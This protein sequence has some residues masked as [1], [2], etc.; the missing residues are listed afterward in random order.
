MIN[1]KK[2][3]HIFWHGVLILLLAQII[4]KG[5]GVIFRLYLTNK[6]GYGDAGNAIYSGGFQIYALLLTV[7]SIGIPN[8]V[9]KLLSEKISIGDE[10]NAIRIFRISILFFSLIGFICSI[11]LYW[12]AKWIANEV[13]QIPESKLT[14]QVLAPSIFFVSIV[15][16]YRGYFSAKHMMKS[17]AIS[18]VLEQLFK[19]FLAFF[20]VERIS[21][22]VSVNHKTELM[23]AGAALATSLATICG[24]IYLFLYAKRHKSL[25]MVENIYQTE[26]TKKILKKIILMSF[27]IT[28]SALLG[29]LNKTIDSITVVRGL[30]NFMDQK[31]AQLQY[32]ILSGKID[33]LITLPMSFNMALIANLIPSISSEKAKNNLV[34]M[35]KRIQS[36]LQVTSFIALP[37]S[38]FLI[39]LADP[40]LKLLFPNASNGTLILQVSSISIIF[41]MMNQTINGILQGVGK[42]Y[43]P[44][45]ITACGILIKTIIN[46][47][48]VKVNPTN[49]AL[50][51][52]VGASCGTIA[53]YLVIWILNWIYL[54]KILPFTVSLKDILIRPFQTTVFTL[55]IVIP[56]KYLLTD[57]WNEKILTCI[58]LGCTIVFYFLIAYIM[59]RILNYLKV[60]KSRKLL[61]NICFREKLQT[62]YFSILF[63]KY[64]EKIRLFK[65]K[66]KK[67]EGFCKSLANNDTSRMKNSLLILLVE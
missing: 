8:V 2:K 7:S 10:K 52:L 43:I 56:F 16:A 24:W 1:L 40:I 61:K 65:N 35:K 42:I 30:Q 57:L 45:G 50:G 48:L 19:T 28:V 46:L 14:L 38:V 53:C 60:R 5:F 26:A 32:G 11:F 29:G 66:N 23:A 55:L 67:K 39:F 18:Q 3:I 64:P 63:C 44:V 54:K 51:G 47:I 49:F 4:V 20:F 12:K 31:S 9:S 62:S 21:I 34:A 15:S 22:Q 33:T 13:L 6:E 17:I 27:P 58:I 37:C 59:N 25:K 41:V 36:S